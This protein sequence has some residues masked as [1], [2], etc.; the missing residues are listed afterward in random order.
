[1]ATNIKFLSH[2][3]AV[4]EVN[5]VR[6]IMDPWLIGSCYWR[7]WWN[8]PPVEKEVI[9]DIKVDAIYLTHVH[10][11]HWHG[12]SLKKIFP[13]DTLIITH[14]EPNKRSVQ[15][16][17]TM[18]FTN[19][20]VLQ[21]GELFSIGE[22]KITPYQFGLFL[23]DSVLVVETPET[24]LLN[25][26]DCKIAGLALRSILLKHGPFDFA[27]RSHSSANDR[28]CYTLESGEYQSDDSDHYS[29]AFALFMDAVKPKYAVPFASNHCHL[30]KDV[31]SMNSVINDP[32]KLAEFISTNGMMK[33]SEL[34]IMLSGDL[35]SSTDGFIIDKKKKIYFYDKE[36]QLQ[37]YYERVRD[38]LEK[39]YT[40]ENRLKPN[41][42]VIEK[43]EQQIQF[44]PK[45][46][47]NRFGDFTYKLTLFNDNEFWNYKVSPKLGSVLPCHPS[48]KT[49]AEV[50][51][52]I[53]IFM[54]S[55][56]LNMFHH[57]SISKR[58]KYIFS[59]EENLLQ[60]ERFQDLLEYVELGVFPI[61]LMYLLNFIK[62]YIIRWRELVVY[63]QAYI[64][65]RKGMRIYK[66]EEEILKKT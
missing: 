4:I 15:D 14:N 34:K 32:F 49:G 26:N 61:R 3:S 29:T 2:A 19:V 23:N 63:F 28:L 18:G 22:I 60:F 38:K 25:A 11:D 44:I 65:I 53:K 47:R 9:T 17:K 66:V 50:C 45:L 20:K 39:F 35:W 59:N 64:L 7:S 40:L 51:I 55:V 54:D 58:N 12:P 33:Y 16:L 1:M 41:S 52:P 42:R 36:R 13:K 27:L 5:G 10:W 6:L 57:S 30:H 56:V 43:F 8:Y 46:L 62:A 37:L 24:K 48:L 31:F 21:H